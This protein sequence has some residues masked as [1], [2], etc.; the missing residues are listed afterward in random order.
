MK[1]RSSAVVDQ[2]FIDGL[3]RLISVSLLIG[4]LVA[5]AIEVVE[6]GEFVLTASLAL[7]ALL[8]IVLIPLG[9][10]AMFTLAIRSLARRAQSEEFVWRHQRFSQQLALCQDWGELVRFITHFPTTV[11]PVAR[12]ALFLYNHPFARF[13][14]AGDSFAPGEKSARQADRA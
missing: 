2:H 9:N 4:S 6:G 3:L 8:H 7:E 14:F 5:F 1:S 13:E 11:Q 12:T 10:W